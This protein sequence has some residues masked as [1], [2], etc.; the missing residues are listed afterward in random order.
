MATHMYAKAQT[1]NP[2][3]GCRFDCSYCRP[4]FQQQAKRQKHRCPLCYGYVPH[5]HPERLSHIPNAEVVFVCGNGD[6]S[7]ADAGY[8]RR[9]IAGIRNHAA[10]KPETTYYLQSKQ[11][12]YFG[13]FIGDLPRNVVLVTTLET[14]RDEGYSLISLAPPPSTRY[15]Q[16]RGL[17]HPRKV[18][19]IE[20]VLDFD[21]EVFARWLIELH[22]EYVWLGYNSRQAQVQLPEPCPEKL[23]L[24][25]ERLTQAGVAVLGKDLRGIELPGIQRT[26]G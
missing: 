15:A 13:Q 14:N 10:R 12:E 11:P 26:Q 1:W 16:F 24:F 18:V 23:E 6:I 4:S 5:E 9:I 22:P 8:T 7:F 25:V 3:K 20:P 19:T 21:I 17:A 2:F